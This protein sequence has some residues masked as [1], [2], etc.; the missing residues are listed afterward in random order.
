ME[1][2]ALSV[3]LAHVTDGT[4]A[5]GTI[6]LVENFDR[7][8]RLPVMQAITI[9]QRLMEAGITLVTLQDNNTWTAERLND[10]GS[11]ILAIV[12]MY[13]G[14]AESEQKAKR[15]RSA[16]KEARTTGSK[17]AFGSAP[18]WLSRKTKE[19][20]W[21]VD[22][23]KAESI[24][25]VF[26]A[27]AMG[28]GSKAIAKTANEEA[29][30]VPTRLNMTKGRWHS[31]M[32]GLILRNR[33][34]I[35]EHTHWLTTYEERRNTKSWKGSKDGLPI[36]DYYP[37]IVSEDLW[38]R[39]RASIE[40]RMS[41]KRR[42]THYYNIFSGLMYCGHCGAPV[43]RKIDYKSKT[44]GQ[45]VCADRLAGITTC[46]SSPC[47]KVDY[48]LV[49]HIVLLASS[50][51]SQGEI[52]KL[53]NEVTM[54]QGKLAELAA[55]KERVVS[56]IVAT[57]G[58]MPELISKA[59]ALTAESENFVT[60]IESLKSDLSDTG[61]LLDE[62]NAE[63]YGPHLYSTDALSR[64]IRVELHLKLT[65]AVEFIWLFAHEIAVVK[66]RNRDDY[67]TVIFPAKN[68]KTQQLI[69]DKSLAGKLTLP[70]PKIRAGKLEKKSSK[71]AISA[72]VP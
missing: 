40:T 35:G 34:V 29:W 13:K 25:K 26:E 11:F 44:R 5:K 17:K 53:Q 2:G 56:A 62:S 50:T 47:L 4:I 42:D 24:R 67:C 65:K 43:Q 7:L 21:V 69:R 45:L 38:Y 54:L 28:Y 68:S 70:L 18:G 12:T 10:L 22:E 8:S 9:L 71:R 63:R 15:I 16:Y 33:A 6:L 39:A 64:D 59:K 32:P 46:P 36:S 20:S 1:S 52:E 31:Q 57:G 37:A 48:T 30:L 58:S 61:S 51:F 72:G 19:S 14:F 49:S 55:S 3:L 41:P 66:F 60:R 23:A 27:A